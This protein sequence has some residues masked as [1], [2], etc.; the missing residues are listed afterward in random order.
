MTYEKLADNFTDG[1]IIYGLDSPRSEALQTLKK[2]GVERQALVTSAYFCGLPGR[3]K[4]KKNII[5]QNDITN[6]VWNPASPNEYSSN[7]SIK[8]ELLDSQ[9]GI[10]FKDFLSNH[11]TYNVADR[12]DSA[13]DP[14]EKGTNAWRRTSKAGLEHHVKSAATVHFIV[15]DLK[16]DVV[17]SK[18]GHG[19]SITSSELRWLY[20]HKDTNDVINHVKFYDPSGEI[21]QDIIFNDPQWNAYKPKKTYGRNWE[22]SKRSPLTDAVKR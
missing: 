15:K 19:T 9:R 1:D 17:A 3:K 8:K 16:I 20:R 2:R 21:P 11:P 5:I 4:T 7:K 22:P 12:P 10:G 6:A 13:T 14:V 18:M